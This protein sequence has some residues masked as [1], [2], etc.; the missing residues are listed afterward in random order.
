MTTII[1]LLIPIMLVA[2]WAWMFWEMSNNNDL[3]RCFITFTNGSNAKYDWTLT[4]VLLNIFTAGY[5][6]LTEYQANN[7]LNSRAGGNPNK[8]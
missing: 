8:N 1:I 2:F 6:F 7:N 5:Y 3:P 4:F